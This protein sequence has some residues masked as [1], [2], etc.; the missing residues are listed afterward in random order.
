MGTIKEIKLETLDQ[1]ENP[2]RLKHN[3]LFDMGT[4]EEVKPNFRTPPG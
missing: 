2:L 3:K 4:T 1:D